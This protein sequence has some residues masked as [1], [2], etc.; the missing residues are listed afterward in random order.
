[1]YL[2]VLLALCFILHTYTCIH[3]DL[4]APDCVCQIWAGFTEVFRALP[5][6]SSDLQFN[7]INARTDDDIKVITPKIKIAT[8]NYENRQEGILFGKD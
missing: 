2:R 8:D 6:L 5:S 7:G 3:C 1:M 4:I